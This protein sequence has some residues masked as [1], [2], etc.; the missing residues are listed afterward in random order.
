MNKAL[1][2]FNYDKASQM[3]ADQGM[4]II[5]A[6]TKPNVGYLADYYY[7][8]GLPNFMMEDGKS[9]YE[10]FVG[11]PR[12]MKLDAFIVGCTGEEGYMDIVDPWIKD[13]KFWG[14][15]FI[16]V[17]EDQR[18]VHFPDP[19]SAIVHALY[20]RGL[21]NANIG[22]E[23]QNIKHGHYKDL[24]KDLPDSEF[25][26]AEP[27]LWQLRETKTEEEINR[28]RIVCNAIDK[29]VE[30]GFKSASVG[31]SEIEME[32]II[33]K[34]LIDE[35]CNMVNFLIGFGPKGARSV[36]P[37]ENRLKRNQIMRFDIAAEYQEY[38]GDIS[39]VAAFGSVGDEAE[40]AHDVIL[41]TNLAL[42]E[43]VK[44][45]ENFKALRKLELDMLQKAGLTP[46]IPIA[47]HGVGRTVHE[48]PFV[49]E[50][51][52]KIIEPGI[53]LAIE[54]TIRLKGVGSINIEDTVVVTERGIECLTNSPRGLYD[55]D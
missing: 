12:D 25:M 19:V 42:Q 14:P 43:R 10:A 13:R 18:K 7:N 53:V 36:A 16:V 41:N 20:E 38:H 1:L 34:A 6:N 4:D 15:E 32:Q 23:M 49:T 45:G 28:L 8:E 17:G 39:R 33:A 30:K 11:L 5:L 3:M 31:M 51:N 54:P 37:T 24:I 40:R 2:C 44:P 47:A 35:G 52:D 46:L 50:N 27:L 48:H 29:A 26:D 22:L 21:T 55:Y 9:F